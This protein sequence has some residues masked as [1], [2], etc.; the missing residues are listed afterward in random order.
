MLEQQNQPILNE[1]P[2]VIMALFLL[3][4]GIEGFI[5]LGEQGILGNRYGLGMRYELINQFGLF[6]AALNSTVQIYRTASFQ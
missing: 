5:V 4:V 1:M 2:S 3:V 6:P